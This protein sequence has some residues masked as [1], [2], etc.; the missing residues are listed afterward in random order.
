MNQIHRVFGFAQL[1]L[2]LWAMMSCPSFA[3]EER[4]DLAKELRATFIENARAIVRYDVCG[5]KTVL[6]SP[7]DET[8]KTPEIYEEKLEF[9]LIMDRVAKRCLYVSKYFCEAARPNEK[10][11]TK[12][13]F[14]AF[15]DGVRTE[16]ILYAKTDRIEK[17]SFD[18]FCVSRRI[19]AIELAG[20]CSV[21][22]HHDEP[23]NTYMER[24]SENANGTVKTLSDGTR[25]LVTATT[26]Q[27]EE[28]PKIQRTESSCS[29]HPA[30]LMPTSLKTVGVFGLIQR[31]IRYTDV[32]GIFRVNSMS[33]TEPRSNLDVQ[34]DKTTR[35]QA[36][37]EV[38]LHWLS[39]NDQE[40]SLPDFKK[41]GRD[42]ANWNK[43]IHD[44]AEFW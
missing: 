21:P 28:S 32:K 8:L 19:P 26:F 31:E 24:V 29:F 13:H 25:I 41:L 27:A 22:F 35:M 30:T 39:F 14:E 34:T 20:L 11:L 10:D 2:P 3:Q 42:A 43:F 38:T 7:L 16:R 33:V 37:G 4:S 18:E 1:V 5:S 12:F 15:Q 40:L 9:R 36:T 17:T 23:L 44:E 6:V